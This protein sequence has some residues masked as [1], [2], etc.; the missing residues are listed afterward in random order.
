VKKS[1]ILQ[2]FL[3]LSLIGISENSSAM[4]SA[5]RSAGHK[6]A[7]PGLSRLSAAQRT[8]AMDLVQ[9]K[10]VWRPYRTFVSQSYQQ[11]GPKKGWGKLPWLLGSGVSLLALKSLKDSPMTDEELQAMPINN[12]EDIKTVGSYKP[13][14]TEMPIITTFTGGKGE[15]SSYYTDKY[16]RTRP[17]T[18]DRTYQKNPVVSFYGDGKPRLSRDK[19]IATATANYLTRT[20]RKKGSAKRGYYKPVK[21]S[22]TRHHELRNQM[23]TDDFE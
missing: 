23:T 1:Y 19:A 5:F 15:D 13:V 14:S 8:A 16:G 20:S 17:V 2:L 22:S 6:M 12:K 3:G 11:G 21:M 9:S 7:T 10:P 18:R 4:M